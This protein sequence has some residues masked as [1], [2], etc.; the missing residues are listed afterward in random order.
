MISNDWS[1]NYLYI[2]TCISNAYWRT[3]AQ[4]CNCVCQEVTKNIP[5]MKFD[6]T[7][8]IRLTRNNYV[9]LS[10]FNTVCTDWSFMFFFWHLYLHFECLVPSC[11]RAT[12][13][14]ARNAARW[15][16]RVRWVGRKIERDLAPCRVWFEDD[17]GRVRLHCTTSERKNVLRSFLRIVSPTWGSGIN[18]S[19]NGWKER[20]TVIK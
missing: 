7:P 2:F 3:A 1:F 13:Y 12:S 18:A 19:C 8:L 15:E 11:L 5:V 16:R 20:R 9:H 17:W 10:M 4:K 6:P 14:S